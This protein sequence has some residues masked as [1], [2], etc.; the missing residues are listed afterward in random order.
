[1]VQSVAAQQE[2]GVGFLYGE[3]YLFSLKAPPGWIIDN[4]SGQ[5]H[6]LQAVF[7]PVGSSWDQSPVMMYA[8]T[9]DREGEDGQAL[10]DYIKGAVSERK[11]RFPTLRVKDLQ[12]IKTADG[13]DAVIKEFTGDKWG[14]SELVAYIEEK[15]V[16]VVVVLNSRMPE[17]FAKSQAAFKELV[18]SYRYLEKVDY[19]T[20]FQSIAKQQLA[21]AE[22]QVYERRALAYYSARYGGT[23]KQC[24]DTTQNADK[25]P[26]SL[27]LQ[28][29][30]SGKV[31]Q[32]LA[33]PKTNTV[34]CLSEHLKGDVFPAPPDADW[35]LNIDM[36]IQ[37]KSAPPH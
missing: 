18:G 7:Y 19:F 33:H 37:E 2:E 32:V 14:N 29:T 27:V 34:Q 22:G 12:T 31:S 13:K 15:A 8:N 25:K 10:A 20:A 3:N 28:F 11:Q 21:T 1:V 35:L 23:L 30:R 26:F 6:G 5:S 16:F 9:A 17:A 24:L 36:L 4:Q